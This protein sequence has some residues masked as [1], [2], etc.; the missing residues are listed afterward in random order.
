MKSR[1]FRTHLPSRSVS[2]WRKKNREVRVKRSK[3][4]GAF[5]CPESLSSFT[6]KTHFCGI[7]TTTTASLK[8]RLLASCRNPPFCFLGIRPTRLDFCRPIPRFGPLVCTVHA[9]IPGD[10]SL[11]QYTLR[12][13]SLRPVPATSPCD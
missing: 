5:P 7:K 13:K 6:V 9:N 4:D 8:K 11:R 2:K 12:D 10:L 3:Q 1:C